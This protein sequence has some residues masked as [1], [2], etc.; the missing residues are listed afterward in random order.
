MVL[1]TCAR[2]LCST[3]YGPTLLMMNANPH[4]GAL[5]YLLIMCTVLFIYV[6]HYLNNKKN[7]S[8]LSFIEL[9]RFA[10]MGSVSNEHLL[11][12]SVRSTQI[13]YRTLVT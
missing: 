10:G 2:I 1:L 11:C 9:Q 12:Y 3:I 4:F 8:L 13:Q 6:T 5:R 7:F